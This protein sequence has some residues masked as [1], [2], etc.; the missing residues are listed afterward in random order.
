MKDDGYLLTV[1]PAKQ[2]LFELKELIYKQA[3]KHD[4]TKT[5][6]ENLTLVEEQNL[7]YTMQFKHSDDVLNLLAMT[8]FAFKASKELL[9]EIKAMNEFSCQADFIIRLYKK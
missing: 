1:T 4:V 2:H 8:P 5:P 3:H 6:V 7:T 9:E